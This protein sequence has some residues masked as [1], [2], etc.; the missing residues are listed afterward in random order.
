MAD[1]L[2]TLEAK[3]AR[4]IQALATL[5]DFRR[6]SLSVSYRKCGKPNCACAE[7]GHRGHGPQ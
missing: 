4:L 5:G 7:A 2:E 1:M 3:R 6:G